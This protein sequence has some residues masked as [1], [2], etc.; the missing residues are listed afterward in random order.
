MPYS[1]ETALEISRA[2]GM[3]ACLA[4]MDSFP[5]KEVW[6]AFVDHK[7]AAFAEAG[8]KPDNY[9]DYDEDGEMVF[10]HSRRR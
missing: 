4:Y 10:V 6:K 9:W 3:D 1:H 2:Q 7:K 8:V 5:E